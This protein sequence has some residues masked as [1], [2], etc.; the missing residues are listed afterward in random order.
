MQTEAR[1]KGMD[2]LQL[3]IKSLQ[4]YKTEQVG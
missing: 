4:Q 2:T 3:K 1:N